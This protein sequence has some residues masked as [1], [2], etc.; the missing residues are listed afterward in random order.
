MRR[1]LSQ[2]WRLLLAAWLLEGT[3]VQLLVSESLRSVT[4]LLANVAHRLPKGTVREE[5]EGA[6]SILIKG[7]ES[8]LDYPGAQ[9]T[10]LK[11]G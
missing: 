9:Y 8:A 1:L 11:G 2:R 6:R 10:T 7:T 4:I 3:G 5:A